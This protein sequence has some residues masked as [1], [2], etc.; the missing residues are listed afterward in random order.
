MII[1]FYFLIAIT[2]FC[3][4]SIGQ[5]DTFFNM[6]NKKFSTC[7]ASED[8]IYI[9]VLYG[10]K[11]CEKC[12]DELYEFLSNLKIKARYGVLFEYADNDIL[13]KKQFIKN[14]SISNYLVSYYF[15]DV[16]NKFFNKYNI[17]YTPAVIIYSKQNIQYIP[18]FQ[19]FKNG[20]FDS[21]KIKLATNCK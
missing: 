21:K 7:A 9:I 13:T 8:S 14:H 11:R 15:F 6:Q 12:F 19:I 20:I 10:K 4:Q 18:Y 1:R 3:Y 16:N 2:F 17:E 5:C